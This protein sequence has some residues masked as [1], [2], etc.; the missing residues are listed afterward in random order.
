MKKVIAILDDQEEMGEIYSL[1]LSDLI[2]EEIIDYYFFTK[3]H[4]LLRW[5]ANHKPDILIA[6]IEMP[7][8]KGTEVLAVLKK[9]G[10][11][12]PKIMLISGNSPQSYKDLIQQQEID[13][14]ILKPIIK[15]SFLRELNL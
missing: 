8:I 7:E 15:E 5:I 12:I 13:N 2:N 3:P 6:D 10:V 4:S 14:F 1:I 11:Q 9:N